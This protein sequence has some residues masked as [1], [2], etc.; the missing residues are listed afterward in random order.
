[1]KVLFKAG[2]FGPGPDGLDV[3]DKM[4]SKGRAVPGTSRKGVR[5]RKGQVYDVPE[6]FAELLPATAQILSAT[7]SGQK[8]EYKDKSAMTLK[9]FDHER[10]VARRMEEVMSRSGS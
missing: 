1:M 7:A 2:W 4:D 10:E 8:I 9:D 6:S 5:Y 3:H